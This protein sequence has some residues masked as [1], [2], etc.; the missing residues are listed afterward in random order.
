MSKQRPG[1]SLEGQ[2]LLKIGPHLIVSFQRTHQVEVGEKLTL[3]PRSYGTAPLVALGQNQQVHGDPERRIGVCVGEDE[4]V[5]LGL[6]PS[7]ESTPC[8]LRVAVTEPT[9]IDAV[10]GT[11]WSDSLQKSPQN[12]L[13]VPPQ[14]SLDGVTAGEGRS[15]QFVRVD[16][17]RRVYVCHRMRLTAI[18]PIRIP[19]NRKGRRPSMLLHDEESERP[20]SSILTPVPQDPSLVPQ[21]IA[22]DLYGLSFWS[23]EKA[24]SVELCFISPAEYQRISG[25]ESPTPLD[26]QDTYQGGTLP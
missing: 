10:S 24:V 16:R 11:L 14:R 3:P 4:A 2:Y 7:D 25:L 6:Q 8:G 13:V 18:P 21:A 5:W 20:D 9:F 26:I 12:Y 19:R 17:S 23:P 22:K 15:L 1:W